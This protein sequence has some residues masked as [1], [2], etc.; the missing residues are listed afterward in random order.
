M[1]YGRVLS[2]FSPWIELLSNWMTFYMYYLEFGRAGEYVYKTE[3]SG[4]AGDHVASPPH[5]GYFWA[6]VWASENFG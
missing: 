6:F 4:M 3:S 1:R 2:F 5:A